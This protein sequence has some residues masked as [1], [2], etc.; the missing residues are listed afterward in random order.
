MRLERDSVVVRVAESESATVAGRGVV[1]GG[2]E[3]V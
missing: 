1:C 3:G 2:G